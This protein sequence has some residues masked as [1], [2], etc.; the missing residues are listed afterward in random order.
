MPEAVVAD[1]QTQA[2]NCSLAVTGMQLAQP[3]PAASRVQGAKSK[4]CRTAACLEQ[5]QR[6]LSH[7]ALGGQRQ[8]QRV[9]RLK[10]GG[11][12]DCSSARIRGSSAVKA[13]RRAGGEA[14]AAAAL[15]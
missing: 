14:A 12:G 5:L 4:A 7:A 11:L 13:G 10:L 6:V 1:L 3:H 15:R 9:P 2:N 8:P